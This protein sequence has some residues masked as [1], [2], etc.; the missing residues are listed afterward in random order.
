M[1]GLPRSPKEGQFCPFAGE[2][3]QTARDVIVPFYRRNSWFFQLLA[4]IA[5]QDDG[6]SRYSPPLSANL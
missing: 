5:E 6:A 3:R 2:W 1:A 4:H